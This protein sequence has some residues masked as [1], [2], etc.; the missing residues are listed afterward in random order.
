MYL[1]ADT[2][3]RRDIGALFDDTLHGFSTGGVR[4]AVTPRLGFSPGIFAESPKDVN[5]RANY[6]NAGV[7]L[8][9]LNR[10]RADRIGE[11]AFDWIR[12]HPD[13]WGDNDA[14]CAVLNGEVALLP[15]RYN[16]TQHMMRSRSTVYG[17][18][19]P[20]E[21]DDAR[22]NPSIV[23]FTGAIKPWHSNAA[24]PFLEEWRAVAAELGWVRFRHSFTV[25]RRF[26]RWLVRKIDSQ[27]TA[28]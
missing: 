9:D 1:D 3:V 8:M 6:I 13:A 10:W 11:R 19:D 16:A 14:I 15:L 27:G 17:F 12:R 22:S 21:V 28:S 18:E 25:R 5:P 2:L 20:S 4:D 24:M 26:E 23:H 7:L